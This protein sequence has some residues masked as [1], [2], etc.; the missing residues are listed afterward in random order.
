M[1]D[2]SDKIQLTKK[3]YF[4]ITFVKIENVCIFFL[5]TKYHINNLMNLNTNKTLLYFTSCNCKKEVI[6]ETEKK[7]MLEY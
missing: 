6:I 2:A 4:K 1:C 7:T 5:F 3:Y